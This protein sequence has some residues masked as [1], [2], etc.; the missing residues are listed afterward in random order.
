MPIAATL[1]ALAA[2]FNAVDL[3][4]AA[5][6]IVRAQASG[7]YSHYQATDLNRTL[8]LLENLTRE[9]AG[10]NPYEVK[11][12]DGH[13]ALQGRLGVRHAPWNL[14]LEVESWSQSFE[15]SEV[16][17]NLDNNSRTNRITCDDLRATQA[18]LTSLA[19]CIQ[20]AETFVFLPVTLQIAWMPDWTSWL[21]AGFGYGIGVLGGSADVN[22]NATYFGPDAASPDEVS[23]SVLPDPLINPVHKFFASVE[24]MPFKHLGIEAR[25]GYRLTSLQSFV[26]RDKQGSSQVFDAAFDY[27]ENGDHLWIQSPGAD[28]GT[29]MLWIGTESEARARSSRYAYHAV[30]GDFD[31]WFAA[32]A[33]DFEW[34]LP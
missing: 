25:C 33:L 26:L 4:P 22:L 24:W 8:R 30:H 31:G 13:P 27:P 29:Q 14:D 12:F 23:F 10:T 1:L 6:W 34:G 19:G 21:R 2:A 7:G 15:Q 17:F 9:A 16:P 32:A 3:W 20:A 5:P 11:G 28:P 18:T